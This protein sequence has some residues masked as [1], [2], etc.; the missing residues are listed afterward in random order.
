MVSQSDSDLLFEP[1]FQVRRRD[2][3][4]GYSRQQLERALGG[5]IQAVSAQ[6]PGSLL[7]PAQREFGE[8]AGLAA[9]RFGFQ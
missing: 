7:C 4:F 8:Q 6:D 5:L 3:P 9:T 2:Q 1:G